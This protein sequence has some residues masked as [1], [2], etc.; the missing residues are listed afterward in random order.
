ARGVVL[1]DHAGGVQGNDRVDVVGVPRL[2]VALDHLPQRRGGGAHA[3][4]IGSYPLEQGA[5]TIST[6]AGSSPVFRTVLRHS[7]RSRAKV[8]AGAGCSSPSITS[9]AEPDTT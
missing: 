8:P 6:D 2:V 3:Q 7:G 1:E 4:S 5:D 9:A